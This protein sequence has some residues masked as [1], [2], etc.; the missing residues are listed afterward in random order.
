MSLTGSAG[1]GGL[2]CGAVDQIYPGQIQPVASNAF[3]IDSGIR[4]GP[5]HRRRADPGAKAPTLATNEQV[6]RMR[7]GPVLVDISID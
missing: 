5:G 2:R 1:H 6:S 4:C 7:P 3:E